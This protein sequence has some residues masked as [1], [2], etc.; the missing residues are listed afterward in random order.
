MFTGLWRIPGFYIQHYKNKAPRILERTNMHFKNI[1]IYGIKSSNRHLK[2][3]NVLV[4]IINSSISCI[5]DK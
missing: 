2:K 1:L 4:Y 3:I 5:Q